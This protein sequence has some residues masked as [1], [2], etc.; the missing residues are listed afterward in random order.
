M[1]INKTQTIN[2]FCESNKI[3][4]SMFYKLLRQGKGPRL[5]KVGR[6]RL[7]TPEAAAAWRETMQSNP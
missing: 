1:S 2:D 4:R 5:M 6:K 7:V 3:S